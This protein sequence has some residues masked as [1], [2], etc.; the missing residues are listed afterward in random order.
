[1]EDSEDIIK[2]VYDPS[3]IGYKIPAPKAFTG[4]TTD[5]TNSD[6]DSH[7]EINANGDYINGWNFFTSLGPGNTVNIGG[8]TIYFPG[9]GSRD[10][11]GIWPDTA[12]G[13]FWSAVPK[14]DVSAWD[15]GI[16]ILPDFGPLVHT[17][18]NNSRSEGY[19][20]RPVHE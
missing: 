14:N 4:F 15:M 3:P 6:G 18:Y 8:P 20:I 16:G 19:S 1:M 9:L 5:G 17:Q 7:P 2:T 13:I 10:E 11:E 12:F